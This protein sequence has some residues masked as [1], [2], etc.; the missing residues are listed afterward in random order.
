MDSHRQQSRPRRRWGRRLLITLSVLLVLLGIAGFVVDRLGASYAE[1][2]IA[3]RVAAQVAD[4]GATS[5]APDVTIGGVPFV[6]QVLAGEYQQITIGLRDFKGPA[7]NGQTVRLPLLDIRANDVR[8]PLA[9]IRSGSGQIVATTV[10]GVGTVD[11]AGLAE[12]VGRDGIALGERDGKLTM[13]G[14]VEALGRT[15]TITGTA[16]LTVVDD[17]LRVRFAELTAEGV[18]GLPAVQDLLDSYA[19]DVSVDVKLPKLPLR[20]AVTA[21]QPRPEGLVVTAAADEVPLGAGGL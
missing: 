10:T 14:P 2:L 12:L 16:E 1:Q 9:A 11:Y 8:A 3:D 18:T 7:G 20:L 5:A 13:R 19:K 17:V 4:N 21:V 6:T 15:F